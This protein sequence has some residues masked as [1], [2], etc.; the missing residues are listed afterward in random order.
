MEKLSWLASEGRFEV[1]ESS[2]SNP[3]S[4]APPP[5]VPP[6]PHDDTELQGCDPHREKEELAYAQDYLN[7]VS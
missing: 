4:V 3:D 5:P 1:I 7:R 6:L 2:L